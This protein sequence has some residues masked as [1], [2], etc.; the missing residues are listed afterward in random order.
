ME[1]PSPLHQES[2]ALPR[3]SAGLTRSAVILLPS[4][5]NLF[6]PLGFSP[7]SFKSLCLYNEVIMR[8]RCE[9]MCLTSLLISYLNLKNLPFG[10]EQL[11]FLEGFFCFVLFK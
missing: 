10:S 7:L 8:V 1:I 3:L 5:L 6:P 4:L 2:V 9:S 11:F